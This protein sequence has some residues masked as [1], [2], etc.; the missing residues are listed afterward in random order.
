[1]WPFMKPRSGQTLWEARPAPAGYLPD[2]REVAGFRVRLK[3]R[4]PTFLEDVAI[5]A[6]ARNPDGSLNPLIV[7][8]EVV[9]ITCQDIEHGVPEEDGAIKWLPLDLG[10]ERCIAMATDSELAFS[11]VDW[12]AQDT[13][14]NI[15]GQARESIKKK[16]GP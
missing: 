4:K 16:R 15:T 2:E 9:A 6:T 3:R 1:M 13:I 12:L 8:S 7:L 10:P 5:A 14:R 11:F